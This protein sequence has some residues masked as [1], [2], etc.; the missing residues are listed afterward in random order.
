M[1]I[2]S[3]YVCIWKSGYICAF[4]GNWHITGS[5]IGYHIEFKERNSLLW[6][7]ANKTP[8]RMKEFKVTGLTEGLEYEFRVMAIN[9]AG[10]GKPSLPSEP[11]VALDPIGKSLY[12]DFAWCLF[13]FPH[14][15]NI[16]VWLTGL[17]RL[18]LYFRSSW[19][20]GGYQCNKEFSD[21]RLDWT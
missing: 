3:V 5:F 10:V 17:V 13:V 8:I 16:G 2:C 20:T 1:I 19:Q 6:K 12:R 9:L 15:E 11:V 7:R 18:L 14:G 4:S 21:S